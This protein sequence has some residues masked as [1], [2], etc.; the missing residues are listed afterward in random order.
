MTQEMGPDEIAEFTG[1]KRPHA[2]AR[3]LE[4]RG[5]PFERS[6]GGRI[7]LRRSAVNRYRRRERQVV[8]TFQRL[9]E[10]R[11]ELEN[12]PTGMFMSAADLELLTGRKRGSAQIR[13]LASNGWRF[14]VNA[15]G[16][17]IVAVAEVN[18]R[19]VGGAG[20][21]R[22]EPN[23]DAMNGSARPEPPLNLDLLRSPRKRR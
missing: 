6:A 19:L 12:V 11:T 14:T 23:W 13:W 9:A 4:A 1:L 15:L 10:R 3:F 21:A 7:F 22:T 2:Q 16:L 18:R 8:A 17:P 20:Q 5:I